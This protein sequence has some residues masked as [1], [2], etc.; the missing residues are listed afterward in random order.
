MKIK[1]LELSSEFNYLWLK[2]VEDVD[3]SQHCAK[4]LIGEYDS[5]ISPKKKLLED[6]ELNGDIYY[7]CGVARPYV[8]HNN[9]HLAFKKA[10]K[11]LIDFASNGIH[12]II[13]GA[14]QLPVSQNF[15]DISHPKA[16]FKTYNTC[17]NYQFAHYFSKVL[18]P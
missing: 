2:T 8:W 13:E 9:F 1:L 7:L 17:R 15:I 12:V 11:S 14:E 6:I 18:K 16:R 4:C 10:D 5:R 3:L